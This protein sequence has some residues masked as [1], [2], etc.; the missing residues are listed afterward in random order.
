MYNK[1][2]QQ[3][4]EIKIIKQNRAKTNRQLLRLAV[5]LYTGIE[6]E[7]GDHSRQ[8][9]LIIIKIIIKVLKF[10]SVSGK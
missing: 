3:T 10:V 9:K 4:K 6:C 2:N 1:Q 7:T 5:F 8:K